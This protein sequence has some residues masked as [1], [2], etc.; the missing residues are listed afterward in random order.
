[1]IVIPSAI[2]LLA[3]MLYLSF[4]L[5]VLSLSLLG[6]CSHTHT[7]AIVSYQIRTAA[8]GC[9]RVEGFASSTFGLYC[10]VLIDVIHW[11][12]PHGTP[13]GRAANVIWGEGNCRVSY[14]SLDGL[15]DVRYQ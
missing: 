2:N 3:H 6:S 8:A 15:V 5:T 13:T 12:C 7:P 9:L 11:G 14:Y 1:M 10:R 4:Y